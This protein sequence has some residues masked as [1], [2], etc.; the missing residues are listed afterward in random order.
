M[1]NLETWT[2]TTITTRKYQSRWVHFSNS[3]FF[4]IDKKN[5][6]Q[7]NYV[8]FHVFT[9]PKELRWKMSKKSC[10]SSNHT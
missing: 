7:L 2:Y 10:T 9:I 5:D 3:Y 8:V 4:R 1:D 6:I